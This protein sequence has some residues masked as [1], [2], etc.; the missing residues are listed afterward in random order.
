VAWF[1]HDCQDAHFQTDVPVSLVEFLSNPI[2]Y[3]D[4]FRTG[5]L[6]ACARLGVV[7]VNAGLFLYNLAYPGNRRF[8]CPYLGFIGCFPYAASTPDWLQNILRR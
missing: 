1:D 5:L 3:L 4:S 8:P 6:E 2:S 7:E